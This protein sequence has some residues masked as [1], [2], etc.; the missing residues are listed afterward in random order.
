VTENNGQLPDGDGVSVTRLF[1]RLEGIWYDKGAR[2]F[3][4]NSTSGGNAAMGQ[5]WH[6][7]P[8]SE[9]L[10]L[11]FESPVGSVLDSPDNLLVTTP[12]WS[13]PV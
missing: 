2:G 10:T 4:F 3:Y 12:G 13:P 8:R 7:S 11:F 5:V 9:K 1:N 6:Y